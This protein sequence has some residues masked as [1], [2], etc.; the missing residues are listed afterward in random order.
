[1]SLARY[2]VTE[3]WIV[4]GEGPPVHE[5]LWIPVV[6]VLAWTLVLAVA[7]TLLVRRGRSRP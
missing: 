1:M 3:G 7:A 2:P 6:N 4:A 5:A